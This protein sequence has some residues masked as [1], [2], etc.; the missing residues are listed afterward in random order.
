MKKLTLIF[1]AVIALALTSSNANAGQS[2]YSSNGF[3]EA[4]QTVSCNG[5]TVYN[6]LA[7]RGKE[8]HVAG[9]AQAG[10]R[11]DKYWGSIYDLRCT[12][13]FYGTSWKYDYNS[14]RL[15]SCCF[16]NNICWGTLSIM[17][18]YSTICGL[19]TPLPPSTKYMKVYL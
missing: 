9:V 6:A 14:H 18:L 17:E 11:R 8:W 19:F 12:K 13:F 15:I 4:R 1:V 5:T 3:V 7:V 2:Q 10:V 16:N